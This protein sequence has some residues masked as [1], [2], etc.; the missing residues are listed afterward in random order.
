MHDYLNKHQR[1][2]VEALE[3][4]KQICEES[5]I[6]F[7][8]LAG[9]TLGAVRHKGMIPWDDDIDVGLLYEDWYRLRGILGSALKQTKFEYIDDNI[10]KT[11]PRLFGKILYQGKGCIDLFLIAKWTENKLLGIV[12]WQ[13]RRNSVIFYQYSIKYQ[14]IKGV[15]YQKLSKLE[16]L[17]Y[18]IAKGFRYLIYKIFY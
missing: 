1:N 18:Y 17:R 3:N 4:L 8:L 9:S 16:K 13:I 6:R 7:Y 10:D 15:R 5:G 14:F 2:A 12:H 11:Y